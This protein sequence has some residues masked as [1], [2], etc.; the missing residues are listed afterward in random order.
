M[1]HILSFPRDQVENKDYLKP[2]P[3]LYSA[4]H[5]IYHAKKLGNL[6]TGFSDM[7]EMAPETF[8]KTSV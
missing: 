5:I 1:S 3:R 8:T 2:P 7:P 6:H 4:P